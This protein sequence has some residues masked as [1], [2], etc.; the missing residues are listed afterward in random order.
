MKR[1]R[2]LSVFSL[3]AC[4]LLAAGAVFAQPREGRDGSFSDL[5]YTVSPTRIAELDV[6]KQLL[7]MPEFVEFFDALT[8][9]IDKEYVNASNQPGFPHP[10]ADLILDKVREA[11]GKTAISSKDVIELYFSQIEL[12]QP[13]VFLKR[14]YDAGIIGGERK[15]E[16]EM[17]NYMRLTV[18]TKFNP[19]ELS[20]LLD[21][22]K[23]IVTVDVIRGEE[24]DFLVSVSDPNKDDVK[25]F[26]GGQKLQNRDGY[27]TVFSLNRRLVEQ[28][29]R[30]L[31]G[32][33]DGRFLFGENAAAIT[34]RVG[35]GAFEV[36]EAETQ[37]K[38]DDGNDGEKDMLRIIEQV[39]S[40]SAV[41]RD[42]NGKTNTQLRLAL[43]NE[44]TARDLKDIAN[45][46]KAILRFMAGSDKVDADARKL[47]VLL[48]ESEI[49]Q[50]GANLVARINW[51][52]D[53]FLQLAKKALKDAAV[54]V[55]E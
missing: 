14:A 31:Q 26:F 6:A 38:I 9:R 29:L 46:G 13:E 8:A 1:T 51:S 16:A 32:E 15:P 47:I 39:N 43:S 55:K 30:Q 54:K 7:A 18:V 50:D 48:L 21:M 19:T 5:S 53:E 3:A 49:E 10:A 24:N 41:T 40:F 37:K 22:A 11:T 33:R 27:V 42:F 2:F 52:S 35:K 36:A 17:G 23:G 4:M 12:V 44:D 25:L 34:L 45:G 20:D 28:K